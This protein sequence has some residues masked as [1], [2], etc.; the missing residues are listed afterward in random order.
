VGVAD[1]VLKF[2]RTLL[3]PGV[4]V[5]ALIL[6]RA[7][8]S[9]LL[10]RFTG[11]TGE[12]GD[13][14]V[15]LDFEKQADILSQRLPARAADVAATVDRQAELFGPIRGELPASTG[16]PGNAPITGAEINELLR[17]AARLGWLRGRLGDDS[18]PDPIGSPPAQRLGG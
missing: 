15:S 8:L 13:L 10:G 5:F 11:I 9:G 7:A 2:V 6:F 3:W 18:A 1:E 14:K 17:D 12:K 16:G 4:L